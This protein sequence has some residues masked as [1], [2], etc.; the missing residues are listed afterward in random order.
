M[1]GLVSESGVATRERL[2][3]ATVSRRLRRERHV[4][5]CALAIVALGLCLGGCSYPLGSLLDEAKVKPG[6][7]V[8]AS[9]LPER[10]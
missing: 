4:L 6:K 7:V 3:R 8:A 10:C 5:A 1:G 2:Y 9:K